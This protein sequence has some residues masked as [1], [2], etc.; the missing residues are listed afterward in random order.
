MS[1]ALL[2]RLTLK[3]QGLVPRIAHSRC[4]VMH[5]GDTDESPVLEA[6]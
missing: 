4:L 1:T 5:V 2:A 6:P 3:P